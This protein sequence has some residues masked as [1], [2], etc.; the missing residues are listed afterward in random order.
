MREKEQGGNE[1]EYS[2]THFRRCYKLLIG[3]GA[4]A[5]VL[6]LNVVCLLHYVLHHR[7]SVMQDVPDTLRYFERFHVCLV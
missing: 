7:S 4:S 1:E 3:M 2:E 5:G 6:Y